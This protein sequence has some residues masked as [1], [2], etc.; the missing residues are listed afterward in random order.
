MR[1]LT[2]GNNYNKAKWIPPSSIYTHTRLSSL[3]KLRAAAAYRE[4]A[5]EKVNWCAEERK[6]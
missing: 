4:W 1:S 3:M 2:G 5:K 6:M